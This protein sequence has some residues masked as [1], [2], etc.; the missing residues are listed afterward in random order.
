MNQY[1]PT[2]TM[3]CH[4]SSWM[5]FIWCPTLESPGPYFRGVTVLGDFSKVP[6]GRVMDAH[7]ACSPSENKVQTVVFAHVETIQ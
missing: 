5:L 7:M 2:T 1:E 3:E 4:K 6:I